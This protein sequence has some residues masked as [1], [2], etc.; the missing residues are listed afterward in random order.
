MNQNQ[1]P[2][3]SIVVPAFNEEAIIS[4]TYIKL[5][6]IMDSLNEEYEFVFVNDGS[7]DN[8]SKLIKE[9]CVKD[10]HVK[11]LDF[12]R[13]F[14]HQIAISAGIDFATGKAVVIIDADLQDPPEV[15]PQ[16]IEKW[17]EGYEVIYGKRTKR[18][19]ETIFKKVT[20]YLFYRLL[21]YL[22]NYEIPT[23]T[24]DFRLI[25]Y[26]VCKALRNINEKSRFMRGI[27]SWVGFKQT[28][29]EYVREER[30]VGESK[31]PLRKM[32][33]FALDGITSFS[34]RPLRLATYLGLVLSAGAF[35]YFFYAIYQYLFNISIV[36]G[37]TS[38]VATTVLFDGIILVILGIIGEYVG[39]I[40]E[41]TKDRP[42]YIL[43]E[44]V[45]FK[46]KG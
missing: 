46:D 2:I 6:K 25:D 26:K 3:Y 29:V 44:Q 39:R 19:G 30:K 33:H 41:E 13:N 21:K 16:M 22:T 36:Q 5:K 34:Y 42:L 40:Y 10:S 38:I 17:K 43:R 9:L 1:S 35:L 28:Y 32:I 45:G 14:G 8:T 7:I 15:I 20:A 37:W 18:K 11:L 4:E 27:I 31:Y 24:G 12:S 23:D